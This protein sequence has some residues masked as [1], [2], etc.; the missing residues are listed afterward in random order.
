MLDTLW[1]S[2]YELYD[3]ISPP[4]QR[5]LETLTA[6][7]HYAGLEVFSAVA[8]RHGFKIHEGPRGSPDN[9]CFQSKAAGGNLY[10]HRPLTPTLFNRAQI[11]VELEAVHPVVRTN[12]VTGWKSL[13][14][15]GHHLKHIN[16]V[17]K[18]EGKNLEDWFARLLAENHDLQVRHRWES[19]NDL[20]IWDNRCTYHA[21]TPDH[22][23]FGHR[24]GHRAVG[25]GEQPY[26][27]PE[28]QSRKQALSVK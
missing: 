11:G 14:A 23:G 4:F 26:L 13:Y 9:V 28:S 17:T 27:D 8:A 1:A 19:A 2:G 15:I 20:A 18:D 7:Y 12:P 3:R 21:A 24:T 10:R 16:G 6:T 22:A 25:V 5:F